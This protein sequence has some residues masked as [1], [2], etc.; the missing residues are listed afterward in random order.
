MRSNVSNGY[1]IALGGNDIDILPVSFI[2]ILVQ[3]F[4]GVK[5]SITKCGLC[6]V[7]N[8]VRRVNQ[9][10]ARTINECV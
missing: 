7:T 2:T 10:Y 1:D 4:P 6:G 9:S 5:S 3:P 8:Q